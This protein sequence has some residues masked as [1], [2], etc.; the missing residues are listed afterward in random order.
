MQGFRRLFVFALL[1][2]LP[3]GGAMGQIE[4]RSTSELIRYLTYQSEERPNRLFKE[5]GLFTCGSSMAEDR[6]DQRITDALVKLGVTAIPD[7]TAAI[8]NIERNGES[9]WTINANWLLNAYAGIEG[10]AAF[11]RLREM[12]DGRKLPQLQYGLVNA[13]AASLGLTSYVDSSSEILERVF[14]CAGQQP[15]NALDDLILAWEKDDA[16]ALEGSL[17]LQG[18]AALN[19]LLKGRSWSGLRADL[20]GE[21]VVDQVAVGYRLEDSGVE[22]AVF[23]KTRSGGDCGRRRV[24][25]LRTE[26]SFAL[27]RYFI[28]NSDL[29]DLLRTIA[30]CAAGTA[31]R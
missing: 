9:G 5:I 12:L 10:A 17:G 22:S 15:R 29:G 26:D 21:R 1:G 3:V 6:E 8:D 31:A 14:Y 18:K 27:R 20:W 7:L 2:L 30:T 11:I 24:I 25:F 19:D 13:I 28:D 23:F 4:G 16:R